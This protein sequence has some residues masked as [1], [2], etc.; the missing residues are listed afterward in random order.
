[1]ELLMDNYA[2]VDFIAAI[3]AKQ[4]VSNPM[5]AFSMLIDFTILM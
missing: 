5:I 4:V 3:N 2:H 1:V